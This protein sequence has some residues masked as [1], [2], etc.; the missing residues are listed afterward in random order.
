MNEMI[1]IVVLKL[2]A[3]GF[4]A[5]VR[6]KIKIDDVMIGFTHQ[7]MDKICS[8]KTRTTCYKHLHLFSIN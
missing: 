1:A 7:E 2:G 4:V 6:Q 3:V 8:N 5:C